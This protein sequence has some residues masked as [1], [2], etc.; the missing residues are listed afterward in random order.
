MLHPGPP[1]PHHLLAQGR[2]APAARPAAARAARG[3]A[4]DPERAVGRWRRLQVQRVEC[5]EAQAQLRRHAHR[6]PG[7]RYV[8]ILHKGWTT[9]GMGGEYLEHRCLGGHVRS[10]TPAYVFRRCL[11]LAY[12]SESAMRCAYL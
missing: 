9:L 3:R 8:C 2:A 1:A 12:D 11:A 4:G 6:Q 5:G 10:M 7:L